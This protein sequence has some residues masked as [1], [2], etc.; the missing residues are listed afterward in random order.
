MIGSL[1]TLIHCKHRFCSSSDS[2]TESSSILLG[3]FDIPDEKNCNV[4]VTGLPL[5]IT[6]I[7]F[8]EM[9]GK[10]GVISPDPNDAR[11]K[12][13]RLY[14]DEQRHVKG[15]G[16]CRYVRISSHRFYSFDQSFAFSQNQ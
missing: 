1:S 12:S 14:R 3:W 4:Y 8:E 7:E 6:D 15:D 16:R 13:I 2:S 10:Y 5:D 9:M 11:K